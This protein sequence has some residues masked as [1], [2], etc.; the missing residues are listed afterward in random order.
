VTQLIYRLLKIRNL[1]GAGRWYV[2]EPYAEAR[3]STEFTSSGECGAEECGE[4]L[5]YHFMELSGTLGVGIA[6]HPLLFLKVGGVMRGELLTPEAVNPDITS[7]PGVYLGYV[8][9]PLVLM[10]ASTHPL[11]LDSR[12]DFFVTD[13]A[14][15]QRSE[16]NLQTQL[17]FSI[18][19]FLG[20][21]VSHRLYLFDTADRPMSL[22]NDVSFGLSVSFDY[23]RQTY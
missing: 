17:N 6:P 3:V 7:R 4:E 11:T 10:P 2:P 21:V 15:Q 18:T 8:L 22:A 20:L 1:Y 16:L 23:R 13:F 19:R 5:R 14:R 12:L 9:R